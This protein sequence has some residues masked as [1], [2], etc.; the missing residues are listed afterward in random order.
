MAD[1]TIG[2]IKKQ[3]VYIGGGLVIVV[4][5]VVWFRS[6][7]ANA[8][9][10]S[11]SVTDPAGNVCSAV[12][13]NSGYCPGTPQDLAYQQ[14]PYTLAGT[15]AASYVG[16]QIIGYDQNGNPIY[17]SGPSSPGP[18][19]FTSNAEWAQA[20]EQ[21]L[22]QNEPNADPAVIA[23]ALGQYITGKPATDAQISIINQA[24]TFEGIPPVGG[25]NGDP[26]G[27]ITAS[28]G[29]GGGGGGGGK[30]TVPNVI[31]KTIGAAHNDMVRAGLTPSGEH[32]NTSLKVIG[33]TPKA[34][35]SVNKGTTFTLTPEKKPS[36]KG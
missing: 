36:K 10:N 26:P 13:P 11:G 33:Q 23:A 4:V 19:S 22:M 15:N 2:G 34:G 14:S 18:G 16:G 3:Y 32:F 27:I 8:N 20:A 6:K 35:S 9:A 21:Y 5:G 29:G 30:V 28:G 12:D 7:N 31:G 1:G 24:I 25:P 17:S